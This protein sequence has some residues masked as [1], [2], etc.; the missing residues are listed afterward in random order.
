MLTIY[1]VVRGFEGEFDR[2]Q[3]NAI[4]SWLLLDPQPQ[5]ILFGREEPGAEMVAAELG[6]S[7]HRIKRNKW[8]T[9]LL[10]SAINR[11]REMAEY[12]VHCYAN[13]DIIILQ[14]FAEALKATMQRFDQFLLSAQRWDF[15]PGFILINGFLVRPGAILDWDLGV[16]RDWVKIDGGLH[17]STGV[18]VFCYRGVDWG[19]IPDLAIGRSAWDNWLVGRA[20][21]SGAPFV[22]ATE[23]AT[24][25]HQNHS[26]R[27]EGEVRA[28]D[29]ERLYNQRLCREAL[30]AQ[31]KYGF[32]AACWRLTEDG[33][34]KL[35]H[36]GK[37]RK[38][39][40]R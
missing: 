4:Q 5:V 3:R 8:K 11:V 28:A 16:L 10:R 18:D 29:P 2:I 32:D 17:R 35:T 34:F 21:S 25:V 26:Q 13:A 9:P 15:D 37:T 40:K 1:T 27:L 12:D 39:H 7:I 19:E 6:V 38:W 14:D 20:I 31:R 30:G 22:D 24:V 36:Y 23:V 33:E